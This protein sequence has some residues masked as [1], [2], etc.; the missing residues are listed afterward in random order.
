MTKKFKKH[1]IFF[2]CIFIVAI[3]LLICCQ[4][5][6][7][8]QINSILPQTSYQEVHSET[9]IIP[10][11]ITV[12]SNS[13]LFMSGIKMGTSIIKNHTGNTCKKVKKDGFIKIIR[14]TK[15]AI[16][17]EGYELSV[18]Q[19]GIV[20]KAK[21]NAGVLYAI[22]T[23]TQ[24][25]NKSENKLSMTECY[26]KDDPQYAF[27]GFELDVCSHIYSIDDLKRLIEV[28]SHFKMNRLILTLGDP[29]GWRI[30]IKKRPKLTEICSMRDHIGFKQNQKHH[31]N[32][33]NGK[34]Y[35]GFYTQNKMHNLV[36]YAH[37]MNIQ[38][39]PKFTTSRQ[40]CA[41]RR[42]YPEI[43][44]KGTHNHICKTSP[45]A[46]VFWDD[47]FSEM[48]NIFRN[49]Y[50][51]IDNSER[52]FSTEGL[53]KRCIN[54]CDNSRKPYDQV[55][56]Q[57][58]RELEKIANKYQRQIIGGNHL[59]KYSLNQN[60]IAQLKHGI[61]E[62]HHIC[63]NGNRIIYSP[64][65]YVFSKNESHDTLS[66]TRIGILSLED[67]YNFNPFINNDDR[68]NDDRGND[69]LG[70]SAILPT[71]NS[72][73]FKY[74]SI[75]T[76]PRLLAIAERGWSGYNNNNWESFNKRVQIANN[77]L[78]QKDFIVGYPSQDIR[79]KTTKSSEGELLLTM[80]NESNTP[81]WYT[82]NGE[83]PTSEST[84]Y[85]QP[86]KIKDSINIH[87]ITKDKRGIPT[88]VKS[89]NIINHKA[90]HSKITYKH[91]YSMDR[92]NCFQSAL[93]DG[94]CRNFQSIELDD[95]DFVIDLGEIQD[96]NEIRTTW[97]AKPKKGEV[98]PAFVR[99]E[100]SNDGATFRNIYQVHFDLETQKK[101]RKTVKCI[102]SNTSARYI[103]V[104][105]KNRRQATYNTK[106]NLEY[107]W[108]R[109]DEVIVN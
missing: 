81:I 27:R 40:L 51:S 8:N 49:P 62:A 87:C 41:L 2:I 25:I 88:P 78:R 12:S 45:E 20:I 109:L 18:K 108:L 61:E 75:R 68:G 100:V 32:K 58:M 57:Y 67:V 84:R 90:I 96:I 1:S 63:D 70:I 17:K 44:C 22:Q 34:P 31:M 53:C 26:I 65:S 4:R 73:S 29:H 16:N 97:D 47:V 94:V 9:V 7:Q 72:P 91:N 56:F 60:S 33:D 92:P 82:T 50:I 103:H 38:I 48:T 52:R 5:Q 95:F 83:N 79:L 80:Y 10:D 89:K 99:Y 30:E 59:Y 102:P 54:A 15:K 104:I 23:L 6:D 98:I 86:I 24:L 19:E 66:T 77:Y 3:P 36:R 28:M 85:T 42:A 69:I 43:T 14:Q 101:E 107:T 64:R 71:Q 55:A 46:L 37:Q 39:I 35:G 74:A 21:D 11:T 106:K 13:A 76:F 93:I 105:G